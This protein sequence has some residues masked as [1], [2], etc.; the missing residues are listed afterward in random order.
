M[1]RRDFIKTA[2]GVWI[3]NIWI[4]RAEAQFQPG[5]SRS[6]LPAAA[7]SSYLINQNFE[8]TGY[9]NSETWT[10][11]GTAT[12]DEDYTGVVLAGSQS[13]RIKSTASSG[14]AVSPTFSDASDC[15][16]YFLFRP[17]TIP[18]TS[19]GAAMLRNGTTVVLTI[20]I[21]ATGSL[22]IRNGSSGGT[23][24]TNTMSTGTTYHVWGHYIA[25]SGADGF[26][27]VGF[28]TTGTKP[29]SGTS[30]TEHTTGNGTASVN[31]MQCGSQSGEGSDTF[32][33]IYDKVLV[34][35]SSIGDSP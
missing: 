22:S 30:Y 21:N 24:T 28:S 17:V 12:I 8:G 3:P 15:W 20:T 9:D 33:F 29:T 16:V 23:T 1:K 27:S 31:A 32:E 13:L 26:G 10:E 19:H 35:A 5:R 25:G 6:F 34:S 14:R 4:Q 2:A 18:G 7:G 11:F